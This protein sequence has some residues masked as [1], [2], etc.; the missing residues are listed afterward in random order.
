[1]AITEVYVDPSIAADSGTGTIGDPYGD[2]EYAIEQTT[3][4]TTNGT[5][6]NVKSGTAEALAADL[7]TGA[8][9]DT[10][11]TPAW[12][13]SAT[14]PIVI[15]GYTS[16]AGDGGIGI[17]DGGSGNFSICGGGT[18]SFINFID[19]ELRETGTANI[20]DLDNTCTVMRCI[21]HGTTSAAVAGDNRGLYIDNYLYDYGTIGIAVVSGH[22]CGNYVDGTSSNNQRQI[23]NGADGSICYNIVL[24]DTDSGGIWA[25]LNSLVEHNSVYCTTGD[26]T[27]Y[28][29][30]ASESSSRIRNNLVEGFAGVGGVGITLGNMTSDFLFQ[31]GGN[32]VYNCTTA[33]TLTPAAGSILLDNLGDN[34]T[35]TASPFNDAANG[36]FSPVDTGNVKEGALPNV[37]GG[38]FI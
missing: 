25:E 30:N 2:L 12:A 20:L 31:I 26:G 7:A 27:G 36:D 15:Q 33:F 10:V 23:N 17:I 16:V 11:T 14:A 6:V 1:M 34:E 3:F 5:R 21:I 37:V 18:V 35:L 24:C 13:P 22:I 19:M 29:I 9:A 28:G 8:L 32:A 4:D 38:G